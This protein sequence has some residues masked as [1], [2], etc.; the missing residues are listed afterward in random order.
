MRPLERVNRTRR[1]L[2]MTVALTAAAEDGIVARL[3]LHI[4]VAVS[5]VDVVIAIAAGELHQAAHLREHS[6]GA[7]RGAIGVGVGGNVVVGLVVFFILMQ[8]FVVQNP[9]GYAIT[10][11]VFLVFLE[12]GSAVRRR[13]TSTR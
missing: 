10:F 9:G 7:V 6:R 12:P 8:S 4:V 5:T 13:T 3:A 11:L 1:A 2:A